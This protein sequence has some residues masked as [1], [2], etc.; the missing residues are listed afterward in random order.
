MSQFEVAFRAS[1]RGKA[2]C[3]SNPESPQGIELDPGHRPACKAELPYPAP[4]CGA[5]LIHCTRCE[6][7]VACTAAGRP[8][9]PRSMMVPCHRSREN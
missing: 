8:D 3:P 6:A 1:G 7:T 5:W 2:Q 9:D 4:E